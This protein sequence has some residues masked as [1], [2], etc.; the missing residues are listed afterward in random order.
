M[1]IVK[2]RAFV[3]NSA[4]SRSRQPIQS[5]E[6]I[7]NHLLFDARIKIKSEQQLTKSEKYEVLCVE[8]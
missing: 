8:N 4:F 5:Y 6:L 7:P 2:W 1:Y 3:G